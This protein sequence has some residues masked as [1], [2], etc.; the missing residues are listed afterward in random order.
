MKAHGR[1]FLFLAGA[2]ALLAATAVRHSAIAIHV[3]AIR[4]SRAADALERTGTFVIGFGH[5]VV[6]VLVLVFVGR[7]VVAGGAHGTICV[8]WVVG[9]N[10][11]VGGQA[12]KTLLLTRATVRLAIAVQIVQRSFSFVFFDF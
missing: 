10:E 4:D 1:C 6:F 8:G 2:G 12:A 7:G 9:T 5:R 3:P 11:G